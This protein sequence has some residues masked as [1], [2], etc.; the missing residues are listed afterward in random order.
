MNREEFL[1]KI[2]KDNEDKDPYEEEIS[3]RG[4][5]VGAIIALVIGAIIYAL[6]LIF[7]GNYNFGLFIVITVIPAFKFAMEAIKNRRTSSIV[8]ATVYGLCFLSCVVVYVIAF[9][10]GWL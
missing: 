8:Y 10:Y 6:E 1:N 5:K 7:W 3:N 2:R 9:C 4:W